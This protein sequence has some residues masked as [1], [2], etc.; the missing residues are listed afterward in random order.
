MGIE[1][2]DAGHHF[3]S[4]LA[5]SSK[6]YNLSPID[7]R[8]ANTFYSIE[9]VLLCVVQLTAIYKAFSHLSRGGCSVLC[10][11]VLCCVLS[12]LCVEGSG[13]ASGSRGDILLKIL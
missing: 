2:A 9:Y 7:A 13:F 10:C 12:A 3:C 6:S 8:T 11:A 1:I 4:S 5:S